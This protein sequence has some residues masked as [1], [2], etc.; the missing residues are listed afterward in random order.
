MGNKIV[1][2]L[3]FIFFILLIPVTVGSSLGFLKGLQAINTTCLN[4]F[5]LGAVVFLFVYLFLLEPQGVYDYGQKI[6][7]DIFRFFAPL[8]EVAPFFLPVYSLLILIAFFF[9]S[10]FPNLKG[11]APYFMFFISFT[12]MMHF[13]F[14]AKT[15]REKDGSVLKPNYF[16]EFSLIYIVNLSILASLFGLVF[17]DF[18]SAEFFST[19]AD[20]T[21]KVYTGIFNQ[22]FV[23]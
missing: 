9:A 5:S 6:M 17:S 15:L 21:S 20:V 12:L 2:V 18:S 22:L 16:F 7:G 1:D 3:K 11:Y 19:I 10:F 8:V 14:T 13:V 23:P 4:S